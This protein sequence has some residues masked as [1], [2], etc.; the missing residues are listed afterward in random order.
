[1]SVN[2]LVNFI[3]LLNL[4][5]ELLGGNEFYSGATQNTKSK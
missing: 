2:L 3:L 5:E 4:L 1:M